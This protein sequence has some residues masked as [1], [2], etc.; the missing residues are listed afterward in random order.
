MMPAWHVELFFRC[1][2][3][4]RFPLAF[5]PS[6]LAVVVLASTVLALAILVI[7]VSTAA[8]TGAVKPSR[9]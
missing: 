2:G 5:L 8:F 3:T 1:E 6:F 9:Y 4:A 7:V